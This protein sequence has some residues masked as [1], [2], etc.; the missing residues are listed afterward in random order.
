[1]ATHERLY[2]WDAWSR[3][4]QTAQ[5]QGAW[6]GHHSSD[7]PHPPDWDRGVGYDGALR[8]LAHGWPDG[9]REIRRLEGLTHTHRQERHDV[10]TVGPAGFRPLVPLYCAGAPEHMLAVDAEWIPARTVSILAQCQLTYYTPE[11]YC[12]HV[13]VGILCLVDT[14]E[15]AGIRVELDVLDA[16]DS[17]DGDQYR[18]YWRL[19]HA[20]QPLEIDRLA[21]VLAH[22]A[23]LRRLCFRETERWAD[24]FTGYASGYGMP[25]TT[26]P[27][28]ARYDI[29]IPYIPNVPGV[30]GLQTAIEGVA[31]I[32][33]RA[34]DGGT[35]G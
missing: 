33:R 5:P 14:L 19:K 17:H 22:A 24:L 8:L 11:S 31:A 16:R 27:P 21:L 15:S 9:T 2:D 25:C 20:D 29:V 30:A 18:V 3:E 1:M 6:V 7:T 13:G 10:L 23:F 12:Y 34:L 35:H 4:M 26:L 32:A 28:P